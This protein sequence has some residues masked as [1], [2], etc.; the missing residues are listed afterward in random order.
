M[1]LYKKLSFYLITF[2]LTILL[3]DSFLNFINFPPRKWSKYNE[4][5]GTY[6]WYTWHGA[7]HIDGDHKLQTN[8]FKTR[9]KVPQKEKK[10]ILLGDSSVETSHKFNLMPENFLE[11]F[12][13]DYSVVSFGSWGW[14]TDQQLLHLRENIE[15]IKPEK[16]VLWFQ[17]N[18]PDDNI[19]HLGF[20]GPKPTFKIKNN[21]L[22]YPNVQMGDKTI[23]PYLYKSFFYR[24]YTSLRNKYSKESFNLNLQKKKNCNNKKKYT[25]YS[26]LLKIYYN[27][28]LYKRL[29]KIKENKPTPYNK[30][31]EK[32]VSYEK[33]R[34]KNINSSMKNFNDNISDLF[35]WSRESITKKEEEKFYL[36]NLLIKEIEKISIKENSQ[37]Y[38]FF[39][40]WGE[41]F[42][43]FENEKLYV[44]CKQNK[45]IIYSN[46][47]AYKKL[48]FIFKDINN[49]FI[50]KNEN[51]DWYDLFD[52]HANSPTMKNF[53]KKLSTFIN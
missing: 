33:W 12:M 36:T 4:L 41:L 5:Y 13:P 20:L 16:V 45:E 10:I 9:G 6:G 49:T 24:V 15:K 17:T 22:K 21:K 34:Q 52:G 14:G 42:L 50:F 26:D 25:E 19:N 38:I 29:K 40:I 32:F 51:K 27:K 2:F 11:D 7:N 1:K 43:P 23:Y 35:Y 46:K 3:L 8:G 18:D 44:I 28:Q 48:D 30:S 47:N 31:V 37:F 53:M 39:P